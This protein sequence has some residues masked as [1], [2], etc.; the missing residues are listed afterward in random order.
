MA[1]KHQL[2]PQGNAN[3]FRFKDNVTDVDKREYEERKKMGQLRMSPII[4]G[5]SQGENVLPTKNIS[6]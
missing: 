3:R 1:C 5:S 6:K 2:Q 4:I